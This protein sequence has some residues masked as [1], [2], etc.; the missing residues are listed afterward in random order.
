MTGGMLATLAERKIVIKIFQCVFMVD[1][2]M[3]CQRTK[4]GGISAIISIYQI[5]IFK[6][7]GYTVQ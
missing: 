5:I 3:K 4:G 2:Q 1:F 7:Y 6:I